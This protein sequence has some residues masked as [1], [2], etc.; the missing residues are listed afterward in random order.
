MRLGKFAVCC[1]LFLGA[2]IRA[3]SQT[4]V[5][6]NIPFDFTVGNHALPAGKYDVAPVFNSSNSAWQITNH[7]GDAAFLMTNG[8]SSPVIE[9]KVSLLFR[10]MA[11]QYS[12][13]QFWPSANHGCD[14]IR[15][16]ISRNMIAQSQLVQITA[17]R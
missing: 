13:V 12:L 2:C 11:G 4:H 1:M 16:K 3:H 8:V 5:R 15:P 14:V 9:H 17:E 6:V 10:Q 7:Q